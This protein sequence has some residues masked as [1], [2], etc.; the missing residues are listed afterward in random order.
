MAATDKNST[1]FEGRSVVSGGTWKV[2]DGVQQ[3]ALKVLTVQP[4]DDVTV[5]TLTGFVN[6]EA[7]DFKLHRGLSTLKAGLCYFAGD[8]SHFAVVKFSGADV[9]LHT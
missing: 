8:N 9:L 6:G 1:T 2:A 7:Y 5:T 4:E 3:D